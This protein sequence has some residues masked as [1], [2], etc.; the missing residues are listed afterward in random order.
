MKNLS[1]TVSG[2]T[3]NRNEQTD[4]FK[5]KFSMYALFLFCIAFTF[6]GCEN[7]PDGPFISL[8]SK[9]E[10]VSNNWK[11]A[12]AIDDSTDVTSNYN[13]Y[14]LNLSKDGTAKLTAKYVFLGVNL[15]FTTNGTWTF[16]SDSKKI[17]FN[18]ENDSA[19]GVYQILKL[20]ED[21][22]WIKE[23]GGTLELHYVN[24]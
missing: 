24:Q 22:M 13:Q 12:Q 8:L 16:V 19:D 4:T 20:E 17:A 11:I 15:D 1:V 3:P 14:E 5:S 21:E 23:D 6:S 9:V 10:R 18:Y 7:Y 2:T